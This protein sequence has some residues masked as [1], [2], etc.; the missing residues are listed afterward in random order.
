MISI[1][2]LAGFFDGEGTA[3]LGTQTKKDK[4]YP[5]Y[6]ILL[7]QSGDLG[8]SLLNTIRQEYGGALY[9]HLSKG[10]KA[11]HATATKEAYKLY[12]N[13]AEG[14]KLLQNLIPHLV[15]KKQEAIKLLTYLMR[16]KWKSKD[17]RPYLQ[18][19]SL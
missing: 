12:W 11:G 9:K 19:T 8:L 4:Q 17:S 18:N 5:H 1:E 2:Y 6:T 14:I 10:Q 16:N 7:S 3:W 13:K 15:L